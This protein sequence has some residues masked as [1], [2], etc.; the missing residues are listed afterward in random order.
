M[1]ASVHSYQHGNPYRLNAKTKPKSIEFDKF[2]EVA[3]NRPP[4]AKP[5]QKAPEGLIEHLARLRSDIES[6]NA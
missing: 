3:V 1:N 4:P 6:T 2:P 5:L